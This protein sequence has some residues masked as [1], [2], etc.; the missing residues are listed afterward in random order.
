MLQSVVQP[1][2]VNAFGV[3]GV[4][5]VWVVWTKVF[6]ACFVEVRAC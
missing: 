6:P 4:L 1:S 3:W 2:G 5:A